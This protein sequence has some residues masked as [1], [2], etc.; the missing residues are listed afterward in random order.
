MSEISDFYFQGS[1]KFV[2][3]CRESGFVSLDW[4]YHDIDR[5]SGVEQKSEESE[6][7]GG[8]FSLGILIGYPK[9]VS[10]TAVNKFRVVLSFTYFTLLGPIASSTEFVAYSLDEAREFATWKATLLTRMA[11][12]LDENDFSRKIADM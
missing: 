11:A 1:H 8:N 10:Q 12:C 2:E 9:N 4:Q 7:K 6:L 3:A 5:I